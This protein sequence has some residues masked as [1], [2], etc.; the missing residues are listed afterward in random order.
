VPAKPWK[1]FGSA[2]ANENYAALVSY[3]PLKSIWRVFPFFIY[4]AQVMGQLKKAQG[5][6]GY[7]CARL[8]IEGVP[9][10]FRVEGRGR[11][12]DSFRIRSTANHE[13]VE[14]RP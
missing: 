14:S 12:V 6:V 2:N 11:S 10:P 5:L 9:H 8:P 4:T 13:R 7:S 1:G 3:L